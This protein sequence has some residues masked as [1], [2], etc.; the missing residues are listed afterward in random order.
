M[1]SRIDRQISRRLQKDI[2]PMP[3]IENSKIDQLLYRVREEEAQSDE[4][5][6]HIFPYRRVAVALGAA[7]ILTTGT[8]A[9]V[10]QYRE[11][12]KSMS[13]EEKKHL[14]SMTQMQSE[15]A[16]HYSR[17]LSTKELKRKEQLQVQYKEGTLPQKKLKEINSL[18]EIAEYRNSVVYCRSN[19]T[20]YLPNSELSDEQLLQI[21]DFCERREYALE[22]QNKDDIA[23]AQKEVVDNETN[24]LTKKQAIQMAKQYVG[25]IYNIDTDHAKAEVDMTAYED[26]DDKEYNIVL[27]NKT[28]TD[29]YSVDIKINGG[30]LVQTSMDQDDKW[31]LSSDAHYQKGMGRKYLKTIKEVMHNLEPDQTI[32]SV[33]CII[34]FDDQKFIQDGE[35][36]Y[37]VEIENGETYSMTYAPADKCLKAVFAHRDTNEIWNRMK[38]L[39]KQ[40]KKEGI[41]TE[42]EKYNES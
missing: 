3:S 9:A 24:K 12:L 14:N 17:K 30:A 36:V 15:D 4:K 26:D 27:S 28:W 41:D 31:I 11:H 8:Y 21:I 29:N 25:K 37:Y 19:S 38:L 1:R 34:R 42:I 33:Y 20:F 22:Q 13:L 18:K 35:I 32:K 39:K 10:D 40:D 16:D 23:E 2:P 5:T 6:E 7:L